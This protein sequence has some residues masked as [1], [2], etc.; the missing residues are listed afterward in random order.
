MIKKVSLIAAIL[1]AVYPA[2]KAQ[3]GKFLIG[4]SLGFSY[5]SDHL[6]SSPDYTDPGKT[7]TVSFSGTPVFGYFFTKNLMGGIDLEFS[8]EKTNAENSA[9]NV[10]KSKSFTLN[11]L[12]R[13]YLESPLFMEIRFTWGSGSS[14]YDMNDYLGLEDVKLTSTILG[15][16][17]AVGYDIRLAEKI[18]LEPLVIYRWNTYKIKDIEAKSNQSNIFINL[19][20]VFRL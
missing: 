12:V 7:K 4:G 14:V 10:S 13:L 11:P 16:G 2:M 5:S 9:F 17:A 1:L 6:V 8:T 3:S 18:F 15:C 20:L 19:G